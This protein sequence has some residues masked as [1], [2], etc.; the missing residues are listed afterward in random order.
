M[1]RRSIS[2]ECG[3]GFRSEPIGSARKIYD[4]RLLNLGYREEITVDQSLLTV[5][6]QMGLVICTPDGKVSRAAG[7]S[8]FPMKRSG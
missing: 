3:A 6:R 5:D 2:L 8:H 4:Q 7:F 1:S